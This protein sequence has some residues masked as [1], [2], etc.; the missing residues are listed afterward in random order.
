[1]YY[2]TRKY[3]HKPKACCCCC[4]IVARYY[5]LPQSI[6]RFVMGFSSN[7]YESC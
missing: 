6:V 5:H 1:M 2:D 4:W 3:T 7:P